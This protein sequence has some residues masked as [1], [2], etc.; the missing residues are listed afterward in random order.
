MKHGLAFVSARAKSTLALSSFPT[1]H[2][3]EINAQIWLVSWYH[4]LLTNQSI[5]RVDFIMVVGETIRSI[6]GGPRPINACDL[7]VQE[8]MI[9]DVFNWYF[10]LQS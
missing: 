10:Y 8:N 6:P 2:Y 5:L 4:V 7:C 9:T 1:G 3:G